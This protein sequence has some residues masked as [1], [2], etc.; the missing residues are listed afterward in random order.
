V[1]LSYAMK[2][3][4]VLFSKQVLACALFVSGAVASEPCGLC[5]KKVVTNSVLASCFLAEFQ[6]LAGKTGGAVV[7]D[8]TN[9][10]GSR[11]IVDALRMPGTAAQEPDVRFILSPE[12]LSCLKTKLEEPGLVLDPTATIELGNCK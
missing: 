5:N 4:T 3:T 1:N 10:E 6:D 8:L 7:I 9:C 2:N 12:Q 11:G